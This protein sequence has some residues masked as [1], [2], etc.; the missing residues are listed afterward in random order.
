MIDQIKRYVICEPT[1]CHWPM[2][3]DYE[4][5]FQKPAL[6]SFVIYS[7]VSLFRALYVSTALLYVRRLLVGCH[8]NS[9]NIVADG[10]L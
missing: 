2:I 9:L 8:P 1:M 5:E 7:G 4:C 10:V 6:T 3:S